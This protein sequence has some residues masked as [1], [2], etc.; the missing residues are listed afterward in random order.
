[1]SNTKPPLHV[2]VVDDEGM[3]HVVTEM[4]LDSLEH[5]G[6][7]IIL[8]SAYSASEAIQFL[9]SFNEDIAIILLDIV[10]ETLT[11]GLDAIPS[12]RTSISGRNARILIRTGQAGRVARSDIIRHHHIH[13]YY[14]KISLDSDTLID[15][16]HLAARN[17]LDVIN[18]SV[19]PMRTNSR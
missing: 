8:H 19:H 7:K 14:D 4:S 17:Y 10:M 6:H 15:A 5:D 12:I 11:S 3:S 2:L 16:I 18:A 9:Q 13:G 1:M